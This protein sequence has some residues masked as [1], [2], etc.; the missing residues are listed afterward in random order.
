MRE[1]RRF[2]DAL[3]KCEETTQEWLGMLMTSLGMKET[4]KYLPK[5]AWSEVL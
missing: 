5:V 3:P 4:V 1:S 2:Y